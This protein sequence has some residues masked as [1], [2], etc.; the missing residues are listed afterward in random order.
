MT[1]FALAMTLR[2][3]LLVLIFAIFVAIAWRAFSPSR[4]QLLE[5]QARIPF[6]E[7]DD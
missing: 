2:P 4:R 6:R 7:T 1:L 5:N 3:V